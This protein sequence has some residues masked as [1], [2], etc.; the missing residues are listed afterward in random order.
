MTRLLPTWPCPPGSLTSCPGPQGW[1]P[2]PRISQPPPQAAATEATAAGLGGTDG[3]LRSP[4]SSLNI[5]PEAAVPVV[6]RGKLRHRE[7]EAHQLE[8]RSQAVTGSAEM[9]VFA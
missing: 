2:N 3:A 9:T 6:W 5:T 7:I 4:G 1:D 8:H